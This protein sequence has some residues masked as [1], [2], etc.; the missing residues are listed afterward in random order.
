[1]RPRYGMPGSL[2]LL[3]VATAAVACRPDLDPGPRG[4][5]RERIAS[6]WPAYGGDPGGRRW[7]DFADITPRNVADLEIAW[8]YHV[9]DVSDGSGDVTSRTA[10]QVTPILVDGRL[11]LCT[12]FNRVVALDPATGAEHWTY[13][14][15]IDL[16]WRYANQLV[17]RG[18]AAW[19]DSRS[20]AGER[21]RRRIF[22]A[23]NDGRLI[24]LDAATGVPC[25][26]FGS[27][28][29]VD[30][31]RG[32]G[33]QR[34]Q[35]EYQLTSPP[36]VAGDVVV[37]GSAVADNQRQ[38]PPSGV[39]R[40]YDA[41]SGVLRWSWDLAPPGFDHRSGPVSEAG[42]ALGTPNAWAP[43][44]VDAERD[45]VFVPT[46]NAAPDYW[47]GPRAAMSHYGSSVVALRGSTGEVVWHFQTVHNDLW[48]F[49]VPAQPTLVTV[50][51]DGRAVPAVVQ[52]TKMGFLFVL[53]RETG[54]PL[55][56]VEERPVPQ[57]GAPGEVLAPTQP[58]PVLPPPLVR[59]RLTPED[60]WGVTPFDRGRCRER[61]EALDHDGP[62][63]PP[64][65]RGTLMFPG[66]AGGSNW[67]GVAVDP[68][69]QLVLVNSMEVPWVVTL[70]PRADFER[71]R[72]ANPG[73]ELS[74]Q[75]GTPFAM[76]REMLLSP[77]GLPCNSP[78]W[79]TLA[80]VD[81]ADGSIRWQV[82]LGTTR[83][84]APIPIGLRLGVP[85]LGGPLVTAGGLVF[86]AAAMDDYLRAFD[87]ETG[88][89]IWKSR[90]PAGGQATPMSY[91]VQ[92]GDGPDSAAQF[93]VVAAGGHAR[94]GTRL[95]DT[96]VAF[97][98]PLSETTDEAPN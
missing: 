53:H 66:N 11:T 88:D 35:G 51:R 22:T 41:R 17:C 43:L 14:P 71:E 56:P 39:I 20:A 29:E 8:T 59:Q 62:F 60:A 4:P 26:D 36:A 3:A 55:F 32:V 90:L 63:A 16:T 40:G 91:R 48:D 57:G 10:L 72:A 77:L 96:I 97:A 98:L 9:G 24:A 52:A 38:D 13:D 80:A 74:P 70:V 76:R 46:G 6:E 84:I 31:L 19:H 82:P 64:S 28:G 18:V 50:E 69:R 94:A 30:L 87:V 33:S 54:E 15:E 1:V 44:S 49:D 68:E 42:W 5:A 79:G 83:D 58:F 81:L 23:T 21:C 25:A 75:D 2:A 27:A 34:W 85:N 92:T 12:P 93:I 67:G 7:V 86:I 65:L 73:A 95:G 45:L 89:E 47:R 37:V 78:P 61:I